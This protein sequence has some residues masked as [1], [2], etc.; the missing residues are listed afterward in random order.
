M[1]A[2]RELV[3]QAE[4]LEAAGDL[5]TALQALEQAVNLAEQGE[6]KLRQQ[7]RASEDNQGAQGSREESA[8][9]AFYAKLSLASLAVRCNLHGMS[10]DE[11]RK[12]DQV[13]AACCKAKD[14]ADDNQLSAA[15]GLR[16]VLLSRAVGDFENAVE[17]F[18]QSLA[19]NEENCDSLYCFA[20]ILDEVFQEKDEAANLYTK[21]LALQPGNVAVMNNFATLLIEK[22][23][24]APPQERG[25]LL[26]QA[27]ALLRRAQD[28]APGFPAYNLAC[29]AA[30]EVASSAHDQEHRAIAAQE[31][32]SWLMRAQQTGGIPDASILEEDEDLAS[33][34]GEP[35]FALAV[36]Q[37]KHPKCFVLPFAGHFILLR[38]PAGGVCSNSDQPTT[39]MQTSSENDND[40]D[41]DIDNQ[42]DE[43]GEGDMEMD[44]AK[45]AVDGAAMEGTTGWTVWNAS[46]VI[47]RFLET[48]LAGKALP[49]YPA[50]T[51]GAGAAWWKGKRVLDLSAGLGVL[52]I[53]CAK[54]GANVVLTDIGAKQVAT[55]EANVELNGL[56][57]DQAVCA[58]LAWGDVQGFADLQ[59]HFGP[60]DLVLASDL[61]YVGIRDGL[62][63]SLGATLQQAVQ[64][65]PKTSVLMSFE[66]RQGRRERE[67]LDQLCKV[68]SC[69]YTRVH[70]E[71][72]LRDIRETEQGNLASALAGLM[73]HEEPDFFMAMLRGIPT[74]DAS[75]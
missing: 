52:G 36:M 42:D 26:E 65:D 28:E 2:V 74:D 62:L 10:P 15:F 4:D 69:E 61:V 1:E 27:K 32:R 37:A 34:K 39:S 24:T 51:G 70:D 63:E 41:I 7:Q 46:Y 35:W 17:A 9:D 67:F 47:L 20:T 56:S 60:F 40:G 31:C 3:A 58:P 43:E 21:V 18:Q 16:G 30:Q 54:L 59:T 25:P 44:Q 49:G 71:S 50:L 23:R 8:R 75:K 14:V 22:T 55:M 38:E 29:I 19:L 64:H 72:L 57:K 53:A 66:E 13:L 6:K 48:E 5:G 12:V 73:I 45:D 68:T 33:V 11:V